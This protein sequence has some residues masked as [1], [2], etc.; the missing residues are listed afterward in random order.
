MYSCS[1]CGYE[2]QNPVKLIEKHA[3]LNPPYESIYVCPKCKSTCFEKVKIKH[4]HCCGAKLNKT[5]TDY[6]S[7]EC[8][9]LGDK[10]WKME[11][12]RKKLLSD[13]PL[14]KL[15]REVEI[16]N[17]RNNTSYSYGQYVALIK[18]NKGGK[19]NAKK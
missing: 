11:I 15:V 19:L 5:Q 10:L 17:K 14:F 9:L 16:Y 4:C 7:E 1:E 2:F 8:K 18:N 6:C 12:K 3:L 13:T